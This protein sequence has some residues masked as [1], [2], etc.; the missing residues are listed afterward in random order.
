MAPSRHVSLSSALFAYL[1]I[2]YEYLS[3]RTLADAAEGH[4]LINS[5]I[6]PLSED[7][8]EQVTA[9][10]RHLDILFRRVFWVISHFRRVDHVIDVVLHND[11]ARL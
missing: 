8:P 2:L 6:T 9:T 4:C 5:V 11:V 10:F 3:G 1:A 7:L